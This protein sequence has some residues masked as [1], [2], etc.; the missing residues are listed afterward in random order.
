VSLFIFTILCCTLL[1]KLGDVD[2]LVRGGGSSIRME[3]SVS[4]SRLQRGAYWV[5]P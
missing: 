5:N 4:L 2:K 1:S 3:R